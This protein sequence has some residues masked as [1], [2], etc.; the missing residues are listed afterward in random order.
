MTEIMVRA[1]RLDSMPSERSA[2]AAEET[3]RYERLLLDALADLLEGGNVN[4]VD[5]AIKLAQ[6]AGL[7]IL[8]TADRGNA[9]RRAIEDVVGTSLDAGVA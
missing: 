1:R 7:A 3:L 9:A 8:D 2:V 4:S 6:K 5:R